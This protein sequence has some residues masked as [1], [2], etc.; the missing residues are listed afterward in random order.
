[1]ILNE[2]GEAVEVRF[3]ETVFSVDAI[4]RAAYSLADKLSVEISAPMDNSVACF[5]RPK[6]GADI[7]SLTEAFKQ[8]VLDY[9]LRLKIAKE[10]EATR[11]LIL[12]L[13]FSKTG[14]QG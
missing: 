12:A 5:L 14:V 4:K 6:S 10:T 9:D 7:S 13:A 8:A 1:M 2:L 11:N 3:P